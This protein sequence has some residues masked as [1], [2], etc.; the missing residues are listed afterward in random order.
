M[1]LRE[2]DSRLH[3]LIE[4]AYQGWVE[5]SPG[6]IRRREVPSSIVPF[7]VNLGPPFAMIDPGNP[8]GPGRR[9]GS[10]VAGLHDRYALVDSPRHSTCLQVNFTPI[11][12]YLFLGLPMDSLSNKV[13]ELDDIWGATGR[14]L[15]AQL[16]EA[17]GWHARFSLLDAFIV[18]RIERGRP[19]APRVKWAWLRLNETGGQVDIGTLADG[20]GCSRKHLISQFRDQIGLPPKTLA[21]I[22]RFHQAL[23]RLQREVGKRAVEVAVSCGYYDQAHLIRDFREFAGCPPGELL[24]RFL[25]DGG[26]VSGD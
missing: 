23:E 22:L 7:I 18:S 2:P 4:G 16:E 17:P 15:I 25:P 10:F 11:G 9:V 5:K 21:R 20:A 24:G 6:G 12:A 1:V 14:R 8:S 19:P 26:G 3:G 13:I